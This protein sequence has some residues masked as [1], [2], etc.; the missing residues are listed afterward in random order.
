MDFEKQGGKVWIG[1]MW[2]KTE[3]SDRLFWAQ[4]WVPWKVGKFLGLCS[5]ELVFSVRIMIL[6]SIRPIWPFHGY[7]K[8]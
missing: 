5:M 8:T 2:L 6:P 3:I 1:F 7:H 4:F